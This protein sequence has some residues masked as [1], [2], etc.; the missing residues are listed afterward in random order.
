MSLPKK[1]I[2]VVHILRPGI[3]GAAKHLEL[4]VKYWSASDIS[5]SVI[6]SPLENSKFPETLRPFVEQVWEVPIEREIR[7]FADGIA[8][9]RIWK[10]LIRERFDG[11]HTHASKAGLLGRVAA[12]FAGVP[13]RIYTPHGF[14]FSYNIAFWKKC[15]FFVLEFFLSPLTSAFVCLTDAEAQQARWLTSRKKIVKIPNAL[16]VEAFQRSAEK[17]GDPLPLTLQESKHWVL[18]VARLTPPKD[19]LTPIHALPT[20]LL[21]FPE[22]KLVFVGDGELREEAERLVQKLHLELNVFFLGTRTDVPV[23]L[24]RS[25]ISVL[26]SFWEGLPYILLESLALAIPLIASDIPGHKQVIQDRKNGRLFETGNPESFAQ[27]VQDLLSHPESMSRLGESG[28]KTVE[29]HFALDAWLKAFQNLYS[30]KGK[31][32]PLK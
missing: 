27:V 30:Q 3:G 23:L 31:N 25:T 26:S 24:K 16:D 20:I 28:L 29:T 15:F 5:L 2:R 8:F 4:L 1:K 19:P 18:M 12:F 17:A 6:T 10:I 7:L 9:W 11:V 14:Y 22:I 21:L 32:K 13:R